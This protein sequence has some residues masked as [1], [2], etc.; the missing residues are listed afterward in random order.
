MAIGSG[1]VVYA[2]STSGT[3]LGRFG[4]YIPISSGA[5]IP[6]GAFLIT[7][8][9]SVN[10]GGSARA[11]PAGFCLSDGFTAQATAAGHIIPIGAKKAPVWPWPAPWP[12]PGSGP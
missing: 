7:G 8:A 5:A 10:S 9:W 3:G 12:L 1:G 4:P 2:N 6:P 11:M